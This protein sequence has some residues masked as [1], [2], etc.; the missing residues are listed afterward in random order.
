MIETEQ[1][2][3]I[4]API[5][6]VW[7]YVQDIR[8][9]ANLFPGCRDC[10]V[11]DEHDSRWVIKVGAGGLVRTVNVSVHVEKWD[12]PER[13]NFTYKL[14]GEPVEGSGSYIAKQIS[15]G[16]TEITLKVSVSGRG[17]MAPMWEAV[18]RPLLPQLAKSF[19]GQLKSE[20]E[21][22]AGIARETTHAPSMLSVIAAWPLK[23]W[24][25]LFGVQKSSSTPSTEEISM[26]EQNKKVVLTFINAMSAGDS[27]ASAPCLDKEAFTLAKGFGKFAGTRHYNDIVGMIGALKILVPTGLR[28]T[29][30]SITADGDRVVVEF[31]GNGVTS[32]GT[33]YCNQYCMVFTMRNGLIRQVNEY[34]CTILADQ[35]LWPM[36][37]RMQSSAA[38]T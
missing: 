10:K 16:Q 11:I 9:W 30:H 12:G 31:E 36:V 3:L 4:E 37:E 29:I 19:A 22:A 27:A 23:L 32:E 13:V 20:I 28:P 38:K 1:S 35:V 6:S 8:K 14:D 26:S 2:I 33:A 34:F 17:P 24:Q 7:D 18:S 25:L 15:A 5:E 21:Q